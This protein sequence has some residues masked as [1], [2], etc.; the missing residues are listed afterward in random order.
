M[1]LR[2]LGILSFISG[3]IAGLLCL[4]VGS[5]F[6]VG[7]AITGVPLSIAICTIAEGLRD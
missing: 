2:I 5:N 3:I 6:I 7:L 4:F 1:F